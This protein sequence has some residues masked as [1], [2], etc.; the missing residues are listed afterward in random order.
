[1]VM[2]T[3]SPRWLKQISL[4]LEYYDSIPYFY[5]FWKLS[6]Y[7]S[8]ILPF[9]SRILLRHRK[10]DLTN[11]LQH[12]STRVN[13]SFVLKNTSSY[14]SLLLW[15]QTLLKKKKISQTKTQTKITS[16][17]DKI[18]EC[19]SYFTNSREHLFSCVTFK[20]K[21]SADAQSCKL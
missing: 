10:K 8:V 19:E 18:Y 7:S 5:I 6:T 1:M 16:T 11:L 13:K 12:F 17:K 4:S 21:M 2:A 15:T 20:L 3:S 14:S 9:I